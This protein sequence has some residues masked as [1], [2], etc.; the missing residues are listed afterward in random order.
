MKTT[1]LP[2]LAI[3]STLLL[4]AA[5]ITP[6]PLPPPVLLKDAVR[7]AEDY[8]AERKIGALDLVDYELLTICEIRLK[9]QNEPSVVE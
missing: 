3:F 4:T 1:W 8:V 6:T 5:D 9:P 7:V 2:A